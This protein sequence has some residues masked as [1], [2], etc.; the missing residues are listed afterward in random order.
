MQEA[1][2]AITTMANEI[3]SG[4]VEMVN[5]IGKNQAEMVHQMGRNLDSGLEKVTAALLN[6]GPRALTI[7]GNLQQQSGQ[8]SSANSLPSISNFPWGARQ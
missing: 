4:N 5:Q 2:A 3:K 7:T 6:Q 1:V 8:M